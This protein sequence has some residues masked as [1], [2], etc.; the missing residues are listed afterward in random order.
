M[1]SQAGDK[2]KWQEQKTSTLVCHVLHWSSLP[3]PNRSVVAHHKNSSKRFNRCSNVTSLRGEHSQIWLVGLKAGTHYPHVT[4]AHVILRVQ[5]GCERRCNIKFYDTDS[6]FCH[7]AY[8]TWSQVE[9]WSAHAPARLSHFCCRTR[10]VRRD[11]RVECSGALEK[12]Q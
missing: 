12:K 9:L 7:Y 10:F 3:P 4:W 5:L 6:L 8:V 1:R 2:S 11:Q